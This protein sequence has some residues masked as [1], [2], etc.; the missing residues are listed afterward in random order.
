MHEILYREPTAAERQRLHT[1]TRPS[2][3]SYGCIIL[4]FGVAW[5]FL[6]YKCGGWVASQTSKE[7]VAVGQ[8]A[9][10]AIAA[11][12][13]TVSVVHFRRSER[14]Q[15]AKARAAA[16]EDRIQVLRA[17]VTDIAQIAPLGPDEPV[18]AI[19][20]PVRVSLRRFHSG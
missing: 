17:E 20:R 6:L 13:L 19:Q 5:G 15:R 18:L 16:A 9:G 7:A 1:E 11:I 4:I 10:L 2:W 8:A 14:R 12:T 3:A